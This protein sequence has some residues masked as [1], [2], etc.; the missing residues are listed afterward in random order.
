MISLFSD[1]Y[2]KVF[3]TKARWPNNAEVDTTWFN[4]LTVP[5]AQYLYCVLC[6]LETR[7]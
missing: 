4:S 3:T 2:Y 1:T 5:S 7:H 6:L